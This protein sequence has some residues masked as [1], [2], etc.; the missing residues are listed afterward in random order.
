MSTSK[1]DGNIPEYSADYRQ[2][3]PA[4]TA[5]RKSSEN[6]KP[7]VPGQ[8]KTTPGSGRTASAGAGQRPSRQNEPPV[9]S[10][11]HGGPNRPVAAEASRN[12]PA[13]EGHIFPPDKTAGL[14]G[15]GTPHTPQ[16]ID[17]FLP[18]A[19]RADGEQMLTKWDEADALPVSAAARPRKRGKYRYGIFMGALVMIF[20][21]IG[22]GFLAT[23]IGSAIHAKLT[24]DSRLRA[25]DKF[26]TVVVA[27][28]PKPFSSPDKADPDFV[29]NVS[30]WQTMTAEGANYTSYDDAGRTLVPLGD[31]ADAC[32]SL[33]GP[34]CGLQPKNPTQETFFEY[35]AAKTQFHV[36]LYS[37]DSTYVPYTQS[38]RQDGDS[39]VLRVGYIP[40]SDPTRAQSSAVSSAVPTPAKVMEYVLKT[41]PSSKREYIYAVRSAA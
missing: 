5:G 16:E 39:T 4:R 33:F 34:D 6:R 1:K 15:G 11:P 8:S 17:D 19:D 20:A 22:V 32:R 36:A 7:G 31:V 10:A 40:P 35:D 38:E 24:D 30:L 41:D 14:G 37:L 28:D 9:S 2:A 3:Q 23:S 12:S 18:P 13:K 29:L 26:L 25:Y 27:Q 21:L